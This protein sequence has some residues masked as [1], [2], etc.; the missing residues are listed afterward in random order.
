MKTTPFDA[1]QNLVIVEARVVGPRGD[2]RVDLV[3]DTGASR[4]ILVPDVVDRLGYRVRDSHGLSAVSSP[5]GRELGYRLRVR[6]FAA[7]GFTPADFPVAIHDI[8]DEGGFDGLLGWDFLQQFN[9]EIRPRE[10]CINA[11]PA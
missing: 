8:A 1:T 9:L 5:L 4:T 6:K 10:A 3:L 11:E 7:L 2:A